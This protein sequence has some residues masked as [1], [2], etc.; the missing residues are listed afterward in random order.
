[1]RWDLAF[2]LI[3]ILF[4][5]LS[6]L[7]VI[8]QL[9]E[10]ILGSNSQQVYVRNSSQ[11]STIT[12]T[13]T[14]T[15]TLTNSAIRADYFD[16]S[17]LKIPEGFS[18]NLFARELGKV[19]A[20]TFDLDG[21]LYATIIDQG[22]LVVLRDLDDDGRS[23]VT[24]TLLSDLKSPH[25]IEIA[26]PESSTGCLLFLAET[27]KVTRYDLDSNSMTLLNPQIIVEL[28][29]DGFH[30]TR[31]ILLRNFNG[32]NAILTS[33]GSSC[34][35]C[36]ESNEKRAK[37]LISDI[38]G[39]KTT[40]FAS[41]LRNAVFMTYNP[42]NGD[43]YATENGRD[44][45]GDNVPPDEV[46]LIEENN[47]YGWPYCY[48][49][50]IIDRTFDTSRKA[51]DACSRAIPPK[52]QIQAHSAPLGL[53]FMRPSIVEQWGEDYKNNLF[54][55][56]HGSWNRSTPTGYKVVRFKL[57]EDGT[58]GEEQDFITGF[59][60]S[61]NE[62][63]GRPVDIIFSKKGEMFIT[64]DKEGRIYRVVKN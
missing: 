55:A 29:S 19:R 51:D 58:F 56:Y 41:G 46:N 64:D 3:I 15:P 9:T 5:G 45:L 4:F 17:F 30:F 33:I 32:T 37:I 21:N 63:K 54:V 18:I 7:M 1:M 20:M 6:I 34:N 39:F 62:V 40:E 16:T 25:G 47:F 60:D 38:D 42:E 14:P 49:D 50:N 26:C 35:V 27:D 43:I 11:L 23:D 52:I 61:N 13:P 12:Q 24:A 31:S 48:G 10:M 2:L 22:K 59:L 28:P 36:N 8:G 44:Y 57:N 53:R